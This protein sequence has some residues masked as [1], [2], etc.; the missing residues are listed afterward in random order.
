M[1]SI[2]DSCVDS[3]WRKLQAFAAN[4][5]LFTSTIELAFG[6]GADANAFRV[7]WLNGDKTGM[8]TVEICPTSEVNGANGA[9][10]AATNKIYLAQDFVD[11]HVIY[12]EAIT[13]VLLEEYGH[14][15]DSQINDCDSEGD[16]GYIFAR[17]VQGRSISQSEL[18]LLKAE[19]DTATTIVDGRLVQIEQNTSLNAAAEDPLLIYTFKGNPG[20]EQIDM[21]SAEWVK[22]SRKYDALYA[23]HLLWE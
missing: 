4:D 17:L 16:E 21:D 3:L 1:P 22:G 11:S 2:L 18:D 14:F 13:A 19:D 8:P 7:A 10:V 5:A 23:W 15:I 9:F 12:P 6:V 20:G